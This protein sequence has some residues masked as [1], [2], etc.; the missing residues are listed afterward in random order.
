[1]FGYTLTSLPLLRAGLA[2]SAVVPIAFTSD[3]LSIAT[4]ELVDNVIIVAPRSDGCG[5]R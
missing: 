5:P 4:M 1:V 3:T 2:L